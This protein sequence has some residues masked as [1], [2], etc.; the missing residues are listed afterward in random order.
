MYFVLQEQ[1][2]VKTLRLM[3]SG[4]QDFEIRLEVKMNY[5]IKIQL[6]LKAFK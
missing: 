6:I 5:I 4:H 1:E 3:D 2:I